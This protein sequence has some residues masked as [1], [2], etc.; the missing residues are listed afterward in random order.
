MEVM[1]LYTQ[2]FV[3]YL[4]SRKGIV[5]LDIYVNPTDDFSDVEVV[6]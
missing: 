1:G 3:E 4:F 5:D 2:T 6:L